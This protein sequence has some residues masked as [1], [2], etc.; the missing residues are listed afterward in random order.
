MTWLEDSIQKSKKTKFIPDVQGN[1][2]LCGKPAA[3]THRALECEKTLEIRNNYSETLGTLTVTQIPLPILQFARPPKELQQIQSLR[4]ALHFEDNFHTD[5]P[6]V[7][8][9][10]GSMSRGN[11]PEVADAALAIVADE[12]GTNEARAW[13]GERWISTSEKPNT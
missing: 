1:C 7:L 6:C 3:V 9:T 4:P 11:A 5:L 2:Q 12:L 8:Y 13:A 10:D